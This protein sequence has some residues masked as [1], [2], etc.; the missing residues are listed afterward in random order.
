MAISPDGRSVYVG[1]ADG[2]ELNPARDAVRVY[3]RNTETGALTFKQR[4]LNGEHGVRGLISAYTMGVTPYGKHVYVRTDKGI[5][6]FKRSR[7][8]KR[9][10]PLR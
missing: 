6:S 9:T 10:S 5:V 4:V 2:Y 7:S 8:G 3:G 1:T